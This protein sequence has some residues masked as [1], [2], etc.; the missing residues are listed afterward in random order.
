MENYKKNLEDKFLKEKLE[1]EEK[2]NKQLADYEEK[3]K[4]INQNG[5]KNK[6]EIDRKNVE[7]VMQEKLK[8]LEQEKVRKKRE[9]EQKESNETQRKETLIKNQDIIHKSEKLEQTLHNMMKKLNKMKIIIQELRRNV[10]L[11]IFLNKN[12]SDHLSSLDIETGKSKAQTNIMIR[13]ENFEE[14][15]VYYW[16]LE[17][18][19]NRYDMMLQI[20]EKYQDEDFDIFNLSKEEDPL[21]DEHKPHLLGYAF[22]K[23]EPLAYLI[24]NPSTCSIVSSNGECNGTLTV[25]IIP[26]DDD[27]NEFDDVPD[28]INELVGITVNFKVEIKE[29]NELPDNF[30]RGVYVEYT[31]VNDNLTYKSKMIEA[32]RNKVKR[33]NPNKNTEVIFWTFIFLAFSKVHLK[34]LFRQPLN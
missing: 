21:W 4:E 2:L 15:S 17:T 25:D 19:Q 3:L 23:L 8:L 33:P 14:G 1:I 29:A 5:E 22:Y 26:F 18:F 27:G 11:E 20:F 12:I 13:V 16:N 6:L 28:D 31:S 30:C 34:Y 32:L 7:L 24:N 9:C 10:N